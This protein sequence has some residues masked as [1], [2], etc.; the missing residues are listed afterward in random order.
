MT[1]H[2]AAR[3]LAACIATV[4]V[5]RGTE[6]T[7]PIMAEAPAIDGKVESTEW[8]AATGFDGFQFNGTLQPRRARAYIGATADT[9]CVAIVS[10]L[11]DEGGL[12]TDIDRDSLKAVHDDSA[13]IY[14]NPTPDRPDNV[15]YQFLV[16]SLGKGGYNV[17]VLGN[18]DE[19]AA[20]R[21]NWVH[22]HALHDGWWHMET[23]IPVESMGTVREGRKTTDGTW[24]INVTRNWKNPW[25]WSSLTG[26][27]AR[28]GLRFRFVDAP[29]PVARH[30]FTA[31]PLTPPFGTV[32]EIHNPSGVELRAAAELI[33]TR[34]NM[35][36]LR[37]R[38]S[39]TLPAGATQ[40]VALDIPE[41]DPTTRYKLNATVKT[42]NGEATLYSR[43]LAWPRA[44]EPYRWIV[45][46]APNRLPVDMKFAYY[47][48]RNRLG[49]LVDVR[50]MPP[51]ARLT[52]VTAD[53]RAAESA[54]PVRS[55]DFT[56]AEFHEGVAQKSLDVD[57]PAGT[58]EIVLRARGENV[59][60]AEA[61]QRFERQVFPWER[62]PVGRSTDV[63]PPFE[64]IRLE[65]N[66]LHTV[67]REHRLNGL[68]LVDQIRATSA[69]TGVAKPILASPMRL[70]ARI[71]G[72]VTEIA[73]AKLAIES[74]EPHEV[75]TL[76]GFSAGPLT[77]K[78]RTTWD[79][80]GTAK[81]AMTLSPAENTRV[82]ELTLE[83]PLH[84]DH[85][86]LIHANSDRIRAPIAQRLPQGQGAIWDATRVACDD[87]IPNFCPYIYLGS[88][89]R[90]LCWFAE[91]DLGWGWDAATPN[92]DVVRTDS[93]VLLRIHLINTPTT[94][95]KSRTL[96]FGMLAAPVKPPLNAAEKPPHWWRYRYFQDRYSLLGTDINWFS[97]GTCGSVYPAG[98]N[99]YFWEMLARAN[100]TR[101]DKAT[102]ER[103]LHTGLKYY[104]PY[105]PKKVDSYKRH[106]RH[107]LRS[108]YQNAMVFYYNRASHQACE[109]F[110]TFK[111]E[112]CLTDLRSVEKGDGLGE[113]KIVPT[114][115]FI[116]YNL[117]WY[118]RSF[119]TGANRGVYWDNFFI[120]PS[121]NTEMTDAYRRP[122]GSI[123][124][125]AGIWALRE[126]AKRT[127][128]MMNERGMLPI[129]FAHMTSFN[130]LPMLAF[131]TVQYDWE[132]KYSQGDV[133]DRHSREYILLASTGELAG[134]WP[135][136]LADHG[137]LGADPWTQRTFTAV[138][139]LHELDGYG[140]C[141]QAWIKAHQN[142]LGLL[143]P[144]LEMLQNNNLIV[145][146]Y[147]E[148]RDQPVMARHPD[149][150]TIV[151]SVPGELAVAAVVSYA[152]EN[153]RAKLRINARQL[154]LEPAELRM[155]N[156][157]SGEA[158]NAVG[159]TVDLD[160]KA[161]DIHVL[162]IT[163]KAT[164]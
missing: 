141:G 116:D 126:L 10:Q 76:G 144:I 19:V 140:G 56:A 79:V 133:Q 59:P 93:A 107:N 14:V 163:G 9:I 146:K 118:A 154:G 138:R 68:G 137:N 159:G 17:H 103:V 22:A 47:P 149:V 132:W 2:T 84:P 130:P 32:L 24:T 52:H 38:Q 85:T 136:P 42:E 122:D 34:N 128:I 58:Y 29:I 80:D 106:V 110:E 82:D 142:N 81:V 44:K 61:K 109:E 67:L 11:P 45:G 150:H 37:E 57:L 55:I 127:F 124:P 151:Y 134:V 6:M 13:E 131:C 53:I 23:S 7:I 64:P 119:E 104:E 153:V 112:W 145:Y 156:V 51:D 1:Q 117:Y 87:F 125:A 49:L 164:P 94:I 135:V 83:I 30:H 108:R 97:M 102:I 40:T 92:L 18:P 158:L 21:G 15:E 25:Q 66:T 70:T 160:I 16:N 62:L 31:S 69:N 71:A 89:V 4:F 50:G 147:W 161:H 3:V 114:D 90:G 27:Y 101:L 43:D 46:K 121:F 111:D 86:T 20:W 77:A 113:I 26:G 115:S 155:E 91:N 41:N 95:D 63:F 54:E 65:G 100:R 36:E 12:K 157:E 33:L 75:H 129:T 98:K 72:N 60:D 28:K 8:A 152:R 123:A 99:L 148:D 74:A 105:G 96:V 120:A 73:P 162:R 39:L 143:T 78:V 5:C 88:A 139:I 48:Y 35:P